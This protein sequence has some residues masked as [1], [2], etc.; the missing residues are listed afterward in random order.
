[1][2]RLHDFIDFLI[3]DM[4]FRFFLDFFDFSGVHDFSSDLPLDINVQTSFYG[5]TITGFQKKNHLQYLTL[6]LPEK[7]TPISRSVKVK[8]YP[9]LLN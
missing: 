6:S 8:K 5:H 9:S 1:M 2:A 3:T 7:N 4:I